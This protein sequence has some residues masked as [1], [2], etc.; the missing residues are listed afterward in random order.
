MTWLSDVTDTKISN[1][2][3]KEKWLLHGSA[4]PALGN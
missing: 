1:S 3:I 2:V 4:L